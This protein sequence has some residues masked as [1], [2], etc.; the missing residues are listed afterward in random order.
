M[1]PKHWTPRYL[2]DRSRE[3]WYQ[4]Q[5]PDAPWLGPQAVQ[6]LDQLLQPHMNGVEVG[7]GR[8][9]SWIAKRVAALHSWE[10]QANWYQQVAQ[11]LDR[12]N[13][14]NVILTQAF[15]R[16][17]DYERLV[18]AIPEQSLDFALVDSESNR[19]SLCLALWPKLRNGGFLMLDNANWF[20]PSGSRSPNSRSPEQGPATAEWAAFLA[21][22]AQARTLWTS[23][24]VTDTAFFIR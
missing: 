11:Q 6:T 3:W 4:W 23:S 9:T 19:S 5:H 10:E 15:E 16:W 22:T 2:I 1:I 20:L 12:Q 21:Q 17:V 8:S 14:R 18:Q 24:G 13:I 7:A